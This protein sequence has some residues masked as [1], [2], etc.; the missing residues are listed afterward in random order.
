[1]SHFSFVCNLYSDVCVLWCSQD[2][3]VKTSIHTECNQHFPILCTYLPCIKKKC[4][5]QGGGYRKTHVIINL[6]LAIILLTLCETYIVNCTVCDVRCNM[7][8][9]DFYFR[10]VF[11]CQEERFVF[12]TS[13]LLFLH[14]WVVSFSI[15]ELFSLHRTKCL[16]NH[17]VYSELLVVTDDFLVMVHYSLEHM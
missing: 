13:N 5:L 16:Q 8:A 2:S 11:W 3:T 6:I 1:M 7:M 9:S 10:G 17:S 4:L 12:F 15:R 14:V